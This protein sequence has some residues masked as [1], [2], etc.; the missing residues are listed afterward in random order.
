LVQSRSYGPKGSPGFYLFS[1]TPQSSSSSN[2]YSFFENSSGKG[3]FGVGQEISSA[4]KD[5][6]DE[7]EFEFEDDVK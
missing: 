3:V 7:D 5:I 1:A 6:E 4:F 2:S